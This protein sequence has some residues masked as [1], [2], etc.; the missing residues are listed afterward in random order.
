L[1]YFSTEVENVIQVPLS[2]FSTVLLDPVTNAPIITRCPCDIGA[3]TALLN[4][5]QFIDIGIPIPSPEQI[6]A[7][8]DARVQN[9]AKSDLTGLDLNVAYAFEAA[10]GAFNLSFYASHLFEFQEQLSN[11]PLV[12][13]VDTIGNPNSLNLRGSLFWN[14]GSLTAVF[15][16]KHIGGYTD[17]LGSAKCNINPCAVGSWT[18]WDLQL[19]Y[20]LRDRFSGFLGGIKLS[21]SVQNVFDKNP[22]FVD[23]SDAGVGFDSI[24]ANP[25]GRFA[26]LQFIKDW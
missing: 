3:L 20:Q 25:M 6:G 16:G 2:V 7:I 1:T 21:A 10:A 8:V 11:G 12:D 4:D 5:P 17:N 22:P 26:A 9:I 13:N 14:A 24:N 23:A 18:T 15:T 19:G